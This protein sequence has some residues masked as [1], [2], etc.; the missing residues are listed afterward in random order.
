VLGA[1]NARLALQIQPFGAH[2]LPW[3]YLLDKKKK[4]RYNFSKLP[5]KIILMELLLQFVQ[6]NLLHLL[7]KEP[8]KA[9]IND[10]NLKQM[11][12]N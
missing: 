9:Y 2:K 5:N 3:L 1:P 7:R 10:N 11:S 8:M 12:N 6:H 4:L